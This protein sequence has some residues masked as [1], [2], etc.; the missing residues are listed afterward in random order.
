MFNGPGSVRPRPIVACQIGTAL[1]ARTER[2]PLR[3]IGLATNRLLLRGIA[4]ELAFAATIVTVPPLQTIFG[5]APPDPLM[6]AI[7]ITFPILV[8]APD[9]LRRALLR[10]AGRR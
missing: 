3:S 5:T 7:L 4:F 2:A 8:W 9:E 10:R 1:A 6:L